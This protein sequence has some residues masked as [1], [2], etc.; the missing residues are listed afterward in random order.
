MTD[1]TPTRV[2][3]KRVFAP[4]NLSQWVA[5]KRAEGLTKEQTFQEALTILQA[6]KDKL[7]KYWQENWEKT[8]ENLYISI[9]A[10]WGQSKTLLE[11]FVK[12]K[13][14]MGVWSARL[15]V[16]IDKETGREGVAI[17]VSPKVLETLDLHPDD[18]ILVGVKKVY[19][20]TEGAKTWEYVEKGV[21]E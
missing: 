12:E 8:V 19:R 2:P 18:A 15:R 21:K 13:R 1:K 16:M 17:F 4:Y 9:G 10:R 3:W 11:T 20:R 6:N 14:S 7:P 5:K